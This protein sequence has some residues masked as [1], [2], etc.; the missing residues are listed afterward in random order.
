M[1][2]RN[3]GTARLR[4]VALDGLSAMKLRLILAGLGLLGVTLTE[5]A[6]PWPLKII[7]DHILLQRPLPS[8]LAPLEGLMYGR[9]TLALVLLSCSIAAIALANGSFSYLQIHTTSAIGHQLV[10]RLRR[11]LFA[12]LTRLSLAF[13]NRARSGELITKVSSD[14]GIL[15]DA[16]GDW[17]LT[18]GAHVLTLSGM[19]V[20]M[21]M[22]SW[23]LSLVIL[24]TLPLLF[25]VLMYLNRRLRLTARTQR[26][27]E[28]RLASRLNEVLGSMSLV[29]AFGRADYEEDRFDSESVQ[30]LEAGIQT[31]RTTA[32]ISKAVAVIIAA[33]TAGTVLVGAGLVRDGQMSPG[34]LLIFIAYVGSLYRPVRDLGRLSA[35]FSQAAVSAQ[36]VAEILGIEPEICD[37]PDAIVAANLRGEIVFR[38]VSFSYDRST[39]IL[40]RVSFRIAAGQRVA[41][42]GTSGAG[43]STIVSLLLRLYEPQHGGILID[44]VDIRRYR[45]ES[46][47]REIGLVLQDTVLFGASI[48]DNIAYGKPDATPAEI[49]EAARQAHAH[50]FIVSL[51]DGYDTPLGERGAT[52]S[53]GQRQRICL[54][55]ALIKRPSILVLD[56]PTS[57]VDP[58]SASLIEDAVGRTHEGRTALVIAHRFGSM[59]QFDQILVLKDGA[60]VECGHH[61]RLIASRGHYAELAGGRWA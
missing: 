47:R 31:S 19:L 51:A 37:H 18:F 48:R 10:Y 53:G 25:V 12:H 23:S 6:A 33:G 5:L 11:E 40:E 7:F 21:F 49:E 35:K 57:A 43:K 26:H 34:D 42:V 61:D 13:H 4:R 41:L 39:K 50:D 44:G 60:I 14:T 20:I 8:A 54:A 32:A 36:R 3:A 16:L 15:R 38:N 27:Q 55:R 45:R 2:R 9:P 59:S 46:L 58:M 1:N 52:L 24:L 28:G 29:Q 56:E 30:N 22:L 17:A